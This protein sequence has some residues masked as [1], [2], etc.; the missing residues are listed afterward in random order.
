MGVPSIGA[1]NIVSVPE[2]RFLTPEAIAQM[3]DPA[4][5]PTLIEHDPLPQL[6]A[7]AAGAPDESQIAEEPAPE[8]AQEPVQEPDSVLLRA[9]ALGYEA[10]RPSTPW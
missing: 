6:E 2:G 9:R 5:G 1:I 7:V 10:Q 4:H 8:P 3:R